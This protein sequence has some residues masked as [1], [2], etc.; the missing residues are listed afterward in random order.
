MTIVLLREAWL[1]QANKNVPT[2]LRYSTHVKN[3]SLYNTP[4]AFGI[5]V[6]SLVLKWVEKL[7]GL[8]AMA[9]RNRAQGPDRL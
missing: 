6:L 3:N 1:A 8:E 7:G 4:P 5:Y 9:E 2:M